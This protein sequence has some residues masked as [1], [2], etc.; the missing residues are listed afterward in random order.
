MKKII[1]FV[2]IILIIAGAAVFQFFSVKKQSEEQLTANLTQMPES[3]TSSQ[4]TLKIETL[5]QGTGTEAKN[6]DKITVNYVGTLEDGTKFDSSIDRGTPFVFTLGAGQVIKGWDEGILRMKV[7][8][9]RKLIIPPS[10]A[11]GSQG[12]PG[13]IP[14]NATLIFEVDLLKIN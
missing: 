13:A 9:K 1:F 11:Y 12:I 2:L 14:P 6:G 3:S 7:G 5:A 4:V 8:E 10:L